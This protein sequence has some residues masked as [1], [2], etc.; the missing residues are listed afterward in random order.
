MAPV[1]TSRRR[2]LRA[3][4]AS[5]TAALTGC[6]SG[7]RSGDGIT[8]TP[9]PVPTFSSSPTSAPTPGPPRAED[10]EFYVV[11]THQFGMTHPARLVI[12][13]ENTSD[14]FLTGVGGLQFVIPFVDDDYAGVDDSGQLGLFLAP[15]DAALTVKPE[16]TSA[17]R[18]GQFLPDEPRDR[19][20]KLPFDWPG[21]RGVSPAIFHTVGVPPGEQVS[22][23]YGVY[24]IDRCEAG[25]FT[26]ESRFQLTNTDPP[27]EQALYPARLGFD[28]IISSAETVR[29]DVHE[30]V[31]LT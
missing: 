21:A 28:L 6:A 17:G 7:S 3:A 2:L 15:D 23:E 29:A 14:R 19:C 8:V 24:Y 27:L 4:T 16:G 5:A 9:A 25:R 20:W 13:F 31:I 12:T 26:F 1:E 22:H 30:P 11:I 10:I 18:V